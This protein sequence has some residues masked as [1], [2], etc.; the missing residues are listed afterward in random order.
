MNSIKRKLIPVTSWPK[1]HSWP[2]VGG[3]RHFIFNASSNGF[4]KVIRRVGGRI[5][6]DEQEFFNWVDEQDQARKAEG[7]DKWSH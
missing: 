5:L 6:I 2:A 1:Y 4:D 7:S 3:L